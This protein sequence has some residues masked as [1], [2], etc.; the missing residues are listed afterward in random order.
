MQPNAGLAEFLAAISSGRDGMPVNID[1]AQ[2]ITGLSREAV[3]KR[4]RQLQEAGEGY[5]RL[6]RHGHPTRFYFRSH[7][8]AKPTRP[9]NAPVRIALPEP[10]QEGSGPE[11]VSHRYQ[12]RQGLSVAVELPADLTEREAS[13]LARFIETLPL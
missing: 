7:I 2:Q 8:V 9:E 1:E 6:G 12:L 11:M 10:Q 3:L 4:F 13:R 5:L